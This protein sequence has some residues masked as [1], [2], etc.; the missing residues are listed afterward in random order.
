MRTHE[1][2]QS[3]DCT[4]DAKGAFLAVG[5]RHVFGALLDFHDKI[6][7][8]CDT[9]QGVERDVCLA[10]LNSTH[11]GVVDA[12]PLSEAPHAQSQQFARPV[13]FFADFGAIH[14]APGA[15]WP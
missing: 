8:L 6:E 9:Q 12:G 7:G 1:R 4:S 15:M 13:D 14:T 3:E 5:D 11:E 10:T 2:E